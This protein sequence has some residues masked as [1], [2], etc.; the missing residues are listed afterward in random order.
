MKVV[1]AQGEPLPIGAL[2]VL[3]LTASLWTTVDEPLSYPDF[4]HYR[5][6][7]PCLAA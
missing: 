1:T 3:T 7:E 6:R 2:W 5:R 4:A